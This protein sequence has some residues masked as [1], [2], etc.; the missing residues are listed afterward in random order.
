MGNRPIS[1]LGKVASSRFSLD[2]DSLEHPPTLPAHFLRAQG[3]R[4]WTEAIPIQVDLI[5]GKGE[6]R[7]EDLQGP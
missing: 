3:W 1:T 5:A 7:V 6:G 4:I 2:L